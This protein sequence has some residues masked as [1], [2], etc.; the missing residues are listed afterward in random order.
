[1]IPKFERWIEPS[2]TANVVSLFEFVGRIYQSKVSES[3]PPIIRTSA[4]P[5]IPRWFVATRMIHVRS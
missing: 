4:C 1:M 2:F 3:S 5:T